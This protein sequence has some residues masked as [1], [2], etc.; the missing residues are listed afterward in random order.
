ML[1]LENIKPD[2]QVEVCARLYNCDEGYVWNLERE[3][4]HIPVACINETKGGSN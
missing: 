1:C 3:H 2:Y 4:F